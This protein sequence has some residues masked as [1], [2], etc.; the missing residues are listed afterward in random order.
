MRSLSL[1]GL[2]LITPVTVPST[3]PGPPPGVFVEVT[4]ST[5]QVG[6]LVGIRAGCPEN[7]KPATVSSTVFGQITVHPQ[8]GFLTAT[9]TVPQSARAGDYVL[10]LRCPGGRSATTRLHVLD[11]GRPTRGPATGFGGMAHGGPP[12]GLLLAGGGAVAIAAGLWIGRRRRPSA[13]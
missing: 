10:R 2:L 1:L 3:S 9:A 11:S 5:A 8:D 4:P 12:P 7:G 13:G 6:R